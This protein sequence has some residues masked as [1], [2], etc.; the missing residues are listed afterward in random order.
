MEESS[1]ASHTIHGPTRRQSLLLR[2]LLLITL[3]MFITGISTPMLTI[4][5]LI[6]FEHA[7][8]V[9]SGLVE[10]FLN[11]QF[12]L[13]VLITGFS[14]VLPVLKLW[15]LWQLSG[16]E[17]NLDAVTRKRLHLMHQYGRWAMLDVMVVA[18]MIMS[19]KLGAL[20]SI[21]VHYGLYV[22]GVAVLMIMLITHWIIKLTNA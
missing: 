9:I 20:A 16:P 2:T 10:L 8:S 19:V 13:F 6:V 11:G 3:A 12:F 22:F 14:I 4:T 5:K 18:I 7:F 21:Q 1:S 15:I 17:P